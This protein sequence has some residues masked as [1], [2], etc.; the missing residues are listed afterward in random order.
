MS[1]LL[2][3]RDPAQPSLF[4]WQVFWTRLGSGRNTQHP[5]FLLHGREPPNSFRKHLATS[6]KETTHTAAH[7]FGHTP[8]GRAP[9]R[10]KK[11]MFVRHLVWLLAFNVKAVW[12]STHV[13]VCV[14]VP[15]V[16]AP[17]ISKIDSLTQCLCVFH[18]LYDR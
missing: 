4:C 12:L 5:L 9:N 14:Y 1:V 17:F 8:P 16:G 13:W 6:L 11:S 15:H 3:V 10:Q 2:L 18:R 7:G